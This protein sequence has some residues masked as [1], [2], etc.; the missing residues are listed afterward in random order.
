MQGISTIT[1]KGQV[2]IPKGI[3]DFFK[4]NASDKLHFSIQDNKIVAIP[5]VSIKEMKGFIKTQ[6]TL[7]KQGMKKI[8]KDS[9]LN[10]HADNS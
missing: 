3:R 5:I 6:R 4:L 1:Q 7:S 9:V 8:I 10:K 2:A